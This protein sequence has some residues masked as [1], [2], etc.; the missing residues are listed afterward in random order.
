MMQMCLPSNNLK[1]RFLDV[2][3]AEQNLVNIS[4]G[5]AKSGKK[6]II[7]GFCTFLTFNV[8]NN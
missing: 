6:P 4:A 3:V 2:G 8:M 5:L 7:Y 1:Q